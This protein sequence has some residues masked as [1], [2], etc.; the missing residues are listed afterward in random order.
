MKALNT[1]LSMAYNQLRIAK[2]IQETPT[3]APSCSGAARP[4]RQY[5]YK[6]RPIPDVPRAAY[7]GAFNR[8]YSLSSAP[9]IDDLPKVTVKR[10]TGGKGLELVPRCARGRRYAGGAA[11]GRP[12]RLNDSAAPLLLSAAAGHHTDDVAHQVGAEEHAAQDRLFYRQPR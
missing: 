3:R 1:D 2:V 11:A 5:R 10:V 8:C 6:G 4:G 7:R 9:E 12:L